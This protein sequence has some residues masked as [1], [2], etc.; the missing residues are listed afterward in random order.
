[1]QIHLIYVG[2]EQKAHS[3]EKGTVYTRFAVK[4]YS[5]WSMDKPEAWTDKG[6]KFSYIVTLGNYVILL[7]SWKQ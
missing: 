7:Y 3:P 1:M 6:W 5:P 4:Y 2:D